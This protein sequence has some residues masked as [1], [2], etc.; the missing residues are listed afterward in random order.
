MLVQIEKI[1]DKSCDKDSSK[2]GHFKRSQL[3]RAVMCLLSGKLK[4]SPVTSHLLGLSRRS[5]GF[6]AQLTTFSSQQPQ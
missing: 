5:F 3:M 2:R 6:K 1:E 4:D